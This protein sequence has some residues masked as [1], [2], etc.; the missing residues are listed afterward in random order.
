MKLAATQIFDDHENKCWALDV[1][2]VD[3]VQIYRQRPPF[4]QWFKTKYMIARTLMTCRPP[5]VIYCTR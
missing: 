3:R 5:F 1:R 2:I 4:W